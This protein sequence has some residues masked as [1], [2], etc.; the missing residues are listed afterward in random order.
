MIPRRPYRVASMI[1]ILGVGVGAAVAQDSGATTRPAPPPQAPRAASSAPSSAPASAPAAL[2]PIADKMLTRLEERDIRDVQAKVVYARQAILS[3]DDK[4]DTQ[5]GTIQYLEAK[6]CPKFLVEFDQVIRGDRKRPLNEKHLF[7]GVWYVHLNGRDNINSVERTQIRRPGD[8]ANPFKISDGRFPLPWGQKK[9][10]IL[11]EYMVKSA[12]ND[13]GDPAD[14]D[15]LHLIPRPGTKSA[16]RYAWVDFWVSR[17]GD[18]AGLPVQVRVAEFDGEGKMNSTL[19]VSFENA[20]LN[21]G[22]SDSIFKI[23][24]PRGWLE[25]VKPLE[26]DRPARDTPADAGEKPK[27][28]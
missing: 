28:E 22:I 25:D 26:E 7:D 23:E 4:P 19:T 18:L 8:A 1:A 10:D 11:A 20:K 17:S 6:P 27:K 15:R 2:D 21:G 12:E 16:T 13:K 3:F 9:A 24:T 5:T 14:T